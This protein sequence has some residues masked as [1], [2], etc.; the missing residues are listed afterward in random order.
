MKTVNDKCISID[1]LEV[2]SNMKI[3]KEQKEEMILSYLELTKEQAIVDFEGER[4]KQVRLVQPIES[5]DITLTIDKEG[6]IV[7]GD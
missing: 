2:V 1:L 6:E 7:Y 3:S 5:V 4:I